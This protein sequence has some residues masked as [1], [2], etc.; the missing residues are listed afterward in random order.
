MK[1][2]WGSPHTPTTQPC[3]GLLKAERSCLPR[4]SCELN[5]CMALHGVAGQ[6]KQT[7]ARTDEK[8]KGERVNSEVRP[9][10]K[11]DLG[12]IKLSKK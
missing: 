5:M 11:K 3:V 4:G 2:K 6:V 9:E 7:R 10:S 12:K 8:E 1:W